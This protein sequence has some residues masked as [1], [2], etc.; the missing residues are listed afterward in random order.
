MN[1]KNLVPVSYSLLL[2][3]LV[4]MNTGPILSTDI[5][6]PALPQIARDLN[7]SE[8]HIQWFI[9]IFL[10]SLGVCQPFYGPISDAIGRRKVLLVGIFLWTVANLLLFFTRHFDHWLMLRV[11]QGMGACVGITISRAIVSDLYDREGVVSVFLILGPCIS[12]VPALAPI[13]GQLLFIAFGWPT[14]FIFITVFGLVLFGLMYAYLPESLPAAYRQ[15]FR[16]SLFV[17]FT[18]EVIK[19][20]RFWYYALV[21]CVAYSVIFSYLTESPFLLLRQGF[22]KEYIGY[23]YIPIALFFL[24]GNFLTRMCLRVFRLSY[25]SIIH[26]G[27]SVLFVGGIG[28]ALSLWF[29]PESYILSLLSICIVILGNGC[30]LPIAFSCSVTT[31]ADLSGSASGVLGFTQLGASALASTM[32][33]SIANHKPHWVG[34]YIAGII[35]VGFFVFTFWR[36][37]LGYKAAEKQTL[38]EGHF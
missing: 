8:T 26:I 12:I 36:V 11:L 6:L 30:M 1:P 16:P 10:V 14:I 31:K 9:P 21:L 20:G 18:W 2:V 4:M 13:V 32:V 35:G 33:G 7:V 17:R 15:P 34:V 37:F 24:M 28:F 38:S 23:T 19:M 29:M 5:F 27:Y 25:D 22:P 3:M